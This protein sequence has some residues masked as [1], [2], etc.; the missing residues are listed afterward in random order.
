[1]RVL[2]LG[3]TGSIGSAVTRELAL[4]G[5]EVLALARSDGSAAK[6]I[7]LGASAVIRGDIAT[8]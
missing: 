7:G 2:V 6:A 1:M 5:H 8:P 3:G 4:R